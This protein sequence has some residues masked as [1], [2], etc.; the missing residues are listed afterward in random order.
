MLLGGG[1]FDLPV[2]ELN[3]QQPRAVSKFLDQ[4]A[5]GLWTI[6]GRLPA[7]AVLLF[8]VAIV[9]F[10]GFSN[11]PQAHN[12]AHDTRHASGFPCH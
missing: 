9:Y 7:V 1:G 12:A 3:M 4:P 11:F 2:K 6:A 5:G 8:G 10:V